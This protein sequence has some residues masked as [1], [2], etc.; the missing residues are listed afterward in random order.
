MGIFDKV[1]TSLAD[2]AENRRTA[3]EIRAIESENNA[4]L[5]KFNSSLREWQDQH[6]II[7]A[8]V[9]AFT[10]A[11]NSE[12]AVSTTAVMK[13]GEYAL[14]SGPASY[15]ES[16][17]Q[18][19]TYIGRSSGVSIPI[20][21]GLRYRTGATKG[22]FVPGPETQQTIDRGTVLMTTARLIFNGSNRSQEWSFAKW[23]GAEASFDET[24]YMFHV[25]NR[26][27]A[28]GVRINLNQGTE[29]NRFLAQALDSQREGVEGLLKRLQKAQEDHASV[30]PTKPTLKVPPANS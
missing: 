27:K 3:A 15:H 21:G 19:G 13:K 25:S 11:S 17:R 8:L 26:Q 22:T 23:T 6:S 16:R 30:K 12:D 9:I 28:S 29:F 5:V 20:G 24:N 14:W 4:V 2:A 1:K 18:A 7:H 10:K